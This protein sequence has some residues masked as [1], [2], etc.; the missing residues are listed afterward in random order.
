MAMTH[1]AAADCGC[2][3]CRPHPLARNNYF[4]GK[5]MCERDFTDE[6]WFFREK[7]RLHHQRLHGTGVVCGLQIRQHPSPACRD[8]LVLLEPGSAIDCCGHDI[9]A[10]EIDTFDFT[11]TPAV[12]NIT[13]KKPHTLEF[14]LVWRECPAEDVPILY[15]EC[16]CDDTQSAPNRILESYALEVR[17]DPPARTHLANTG[18]LDWGPSIGIAQ[19]TAVVLDEANQ[20]IFVAA[21]ASPQTIYQVDT[22]HLLIEASYVTTGTVQS[23]ALAPGGATLYAVINSGS[24]TAVQ[25][26]TPSA[27]GLTPSGAAL[28]SNNGTVSIALTSGAPGLLGMDTSTGNYGFAATPVNL[29]SSVPGTLGGASSPAVFST[30]GTTAWAVTGTTL[31][32]IAL[33]AGT[34]NTPITLPATILAATTVAMVPNGKGTDFLAIAADPYL[35]LFD[36]A[37]QTILGSTKLTARPSAILVTADG[38]TAIVTGI[39]DIQTVNLTALAQGAAD[40]AGPDYKLEAGI[41][42]SAMSADGSLVYVPFTGGSSAANQGGVAVVSWTTHDC[43][44]ALRGETCP[45]CEPPD[46]LVLARVT[47]WTAGTALQDMPNP[48]GTPPSG[49]V[50]IDNNVRTVLAS[51]QAITNT[52]LCLMDQPKLATSSPAQTAPAPAKTKLTHISAIDWPHAQTYN[53]FLN[54][55]PPTLSLA[56]DGQVNAAD[57]MQPTALMVL[58]SLYVSPDSQNWLLTWCQ[59]PVTSFGFSNESPLPPGQIPSAAV[60]E[61]VAGPA[62]AGTT[63]PPNPPAAPATCTSMQMTL[64]PARLEL[65]VTAAANAGQPLFVRVLLNGDLVRDAS[66]QQLALDANHLPPWFGAQDYVTGDGIAGGLFES[67]FQFTSLVEKEPQPPGGVREPQPPSQTSGSQLSGNQTTGTLVSGN[68]TTGTLVSGNQTT[69]TPLLPPTYVSSGGSAVLLGNQV[70]D[71]PATPSNRQAPVAAQATDDARPA[72]PPQEQASPTPAKDEAP[73]APSA[74]KS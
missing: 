47:G 18:T 58:L 16:G 62:G 17:V 67:W 27:T 52:L 1:H 12:K 56:F 60:W 59:V 54:A 24:V 22:Q 19:A 6:Q 49:V 13:D 3:D 4:T 43:R 30:D 37:T 23:L 50:Y 25:P 40:A 64:D 71:L 28:T 48:A 66:A 21:G 14:C 42:T 73:S 36:P 32:S 15:D 70:D 63:Y 45:A 55:Q 38:G 44:A 31:N 8:R 61:V 68:Q 34:V 2:E 35:H 57:L 69:G 53:A 5:L 72:P 9:L 39:D 51:T 10:A 41:G 20:R 33:P 26:L 74:T 46:C 11:Q 29:A 7:I 65:A